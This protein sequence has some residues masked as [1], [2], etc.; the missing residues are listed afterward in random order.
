MLH[1]PRSRHWRRV[2][3]N[4]RR[5]EI[6]REGYDVT[7]F[8]RCSRLGGRAQIFERDGFKYDAG[9]TVISPF[10]FEELFALFGKDIRNYVNIVALDVGTIRFADGDIFDYGGTVEDT[11]REIRRISRATKQDTC[12]F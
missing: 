1:E 9:P 4:R 5:T 11:R 12:R 8:D 2:W 3:R 6:A 7:L 10:L